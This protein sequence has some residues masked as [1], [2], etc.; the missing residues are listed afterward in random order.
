MKSTGYRWLQLHSP[1][2]FILYNFY[3]L[4]LLSAASTEPLVVACSFLLS[5][6]QFFMRFVPTQHVFIKMS[7]INV[8]H[9][10]LHQSNT[11]AHTYIELLPFLQRD[12]LSAISEGVEKEG[13]FSE[14][15]EQSPGMYDVTTRKHFGPKGVRSAVKKSEVVQIQQSSLGSSEPASE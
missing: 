1:A 11:H 14:R 7:S 8:T 3:C 15:H 5:F 13:Y 9:Q 6:L 4:S 10:N 12:G 2:F